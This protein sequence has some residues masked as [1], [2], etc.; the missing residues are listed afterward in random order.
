MK[1]TANDFKRNNKPRHLFNWKPPKFIYPCDA[2]E[3]SALKGLQKSFNP[4]PPYKRK[5]DPATGMEF[6]AIQNGTLVDI[7][8]PIPDGHIAFLENTAEQCTSPETK[9]SREGKESARHWT[10]RID[11]PEGVFKR[12]T[13]G[14]GISLMFGERFH[15]FIRNGNNW[16]GISGV[17]LDIDV[18]RDEKH[19][20]APNPVESRDELFAQHSLLARICSFIL[21]TASSLHEGRSFKSRGAILFPTP[22]TDQRIYRAFASILIAEIDCIPSNVTS[23]PVAVGFGNTHNAAQAWHNP[24][25]DTDWIQHALNTAAQK[26]LEKNVE[27]LTKQQAAEARRLAYQERQRNSEPNRC[28]ESDGENISTFIENCDPVAEMLRDGLL[29]STGGTQYRWHESAHDRSCDILDGTIHVFSNTMSEASPAHANEPVNTHRFYLYQLCGF[30]MTQNA[31]KPRIREYLFEHG[32]GSDPKAFAAKRKSAKLQR[33]DTPTPIPTETLDENSKN[34]ESA[35]HR[36]LASDPP[37]NLIQIHLVNEDT[38]SGKSYNATKEAAKQGKTTLALTAHNE[39]AQQAVSIALEVG[40]KNPI[41]LK[42][43]EH[44]WDASGIG[45][46]PIGERTAALFER[47][48]CIMCEPIREYTKRNLAPMTYC[49]LFCPFRTD[50]TGNIICKHLQQYEGLADHDFIATSN[51]NLF[52]DPSL[53][54]YL[55]TLVNAKNETTDED[56]AIDAMLGTSSKENKPIELG[57]VDDYQLSGIYPEKKFSESRLKALK[58]AWHS[59]P[60][61]KFATLLLKAFEKKKPQKIVKAFRKALEST[62]EHHTEISK[63]LT[64]HARKGIVQHAA[65][66]IS[67]KE[68]QKLLTEKEVLYTDGGKQFIPVNINAFLELKEK[69]VPVIHPSLID[70]HINIGTEVIIPHT[71]KAALQANIPLKDLTPVWQKGVTP[72]DLIQ[73]FLSQIGNPQNAPVK[74]EFTAA[75]NKNNAVLTFSIPPQAPIGILTHIAMLSAT[76]DPADTQKAFDGQPVAFSYYTGG[77]IKYADGV[78]T[79]Q[80]QDARLTSGSVFEYPT[81]IEGKRQL[82]EPP[83]GLKATA[84]KRLTQL[85]KWAKQEDGL[86]AFISYKEFTTEPFSKYVSG[87]DIVTH[88]DKVTGLNFKGLKYL[89]V[90]GCPKVKHEVL[91]WHAHT[92]HASDSDPL[93]KADP[94][95]LD[96]KEKMIPEYMQLTE[97]STVIENGYE[98]TERRYTDTRL[99]KIRHQLSTEKLK[100][101]LG[102]ARLIRWEDTT[103]LLITNTPVKGFTERAKL[104]SDASLNLAETPSEI[105]A[106]M[107]RIRDAEKTGD[108]Q[109][110]METK[111]VAR[112]Q[113]Y[114]I[115]K[116]S[117]SQR[118]ADRDAQILALHDDGHSQLEIERQLKIMG[119]TTGTSP[120]SIRKV[121]TDTE[122]GRQKSDPLLVYTYRQSEKRPPPTNLDEA[123]VES[124]Q[125]PNPDRDAQIIALHQSGITQ[126]DIHSKMNAA[127]HKV[128]LGTVNKVIQVFRMRQPAISTSYSR[129]AQTEHPTNPEDTPIECKIL[130]ASEPEPNHSTFFKL[131]EIRT[132][133][134]EKK[135]L[136]ASDISQLTDIDENEVRKILN[137][138]YKKVVISP[139]I[140]DQYW[141]TER[142]KKNLWDKILGPAFNEWT[143]NFPGQ[144]TLCPSITFEWIGTGPSPG[145]DLHVLP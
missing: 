58:K 13:D 4:L 114:E 82:Q 118:N 17:L 76:V 115:T 121:I 31:D 141:M 77:T 69:G 136:S 26:V 10:Q 7:N 1:W 62:A 64:Q 98:I 87:F 106:A 84:E 81:D 119:Y 68:T 111:G 33:I 137:D 139:G 145:D 86:T 75:E 97:E 59:T 132:Y 3:L 142:D 140:G 134:Y 122:Q 27:S 35:T 9:H 24:S 39:L 138:W 80:Y 78:E 19:P 51:P 16:R 108:V 30:D 127:E 107:D 113:A 112:S 53:H 38:G 143:E 8:T 79:Y 54:P 2:T 63:H 50:D 96:A 6:D 22:I 48:G 102:R 57:I 65:R 45:K 94:T 128:S 34:R 44:N 29:I 99:E 95:L 120:K 117:R 43:R 28:S 25:P 85:N 15:Q 104:F 37:K 12:L 110:V 66:G 49:M 5:S 42:G 23:N 89:V 11:T 100:Q 55:N 73:M 116:K 40:F 126:R 91:M 125:L 61:A 93:P 46:I 130:N 20:D 41:H 60:T 74:R 144:K 105:P 21:P 124:V 133:F 92:Q 18:F 67:S 70:S 101:S 103:T 36:S 71:P 32:Y 83:T 72:I 135:Q 90:F 47:N 56:L 123:G 129:L 109:A 52:L 14:Y 88:F 131:L